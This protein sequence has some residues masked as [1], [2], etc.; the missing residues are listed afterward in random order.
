[1]DVVIVDDQA[2]ARTMLR[3]I[4]EDIASE[5][6]VHD[7]GDPAVALEWCESN[8]PDL[9][10]LDYRMP[11]IDGLE[12][13]RRFRRMPLHRDIPIILVT[14]VG[15]EPVRQAALDAGVIDFLVK[16][17]RPREL[18][19]RCRNL[20]LLR[21]QAENIKQRAL[22]L[23][24]RLLATM[25][26]V[27][28]RERETLSRLARAI[29]YRDAGT[30]AYLE[31]MA[32]IAGLIAEQ[33]G[34]FEDDV[35]MIEL[36][37]P[38]HDIGKIAIPDSVLLKPGQLTDSE[39]AVMR[40]HPRIGHELLGGSQNRFIQMGALIALRHHERYDGS[41]YPDGLVGEEIPLEARIVAVADVFDA[42]LSPRPYKEAWDVDD[43]LAYLRS[44][45]GHL[46]DP[47][48]VDALL[49]SRPQ[50]D[51]ICNRYSASFVRPGVE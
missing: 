1:M 47:R 3:H 44:Q 43:A 36:A 49:R 27:E 51:E 21:Q 16:P 19:A 6:R 12:F 20:L 46:F 25:H 15:D 35:R 13:A 39:T 37:A 9:L 42:L 40:R 34:M 30:S 10:L 18:R 48:C 38:L 50:L 11:G 32:H 24:Q 29:E 14:V 31:R 28:E 41:G 22:S 23:E 7:F 5:L 8:Q 4:I 17:V 26:E 2:S 33:L 45:R